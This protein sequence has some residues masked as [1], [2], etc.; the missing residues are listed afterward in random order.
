MA[1]EE[2]SA[3]IIDLK[4]LMS[5]QIGSETPPAE[6]FNGNPNKKPEDLLGVN[7][8]EEE[9]EAERI[10]A[11][12]E[13]AEAARIKAEEDEGKSEEELEAERIKAEE[14]EAARIKAEEEDKTEEEIEAERIKA[15][16]EAA[17]IKAE[18]GE[19]EVSE[20]TTSLKNLF[21]ED[22]SHIIQENDKGESVEIAL[23]DVEMTQELY[24]EIL[25]AK[26][27][28]IKE[29]AKKDTVSTEGISEF[30]RE[31]IEID[32]AGGEI[33]SLLEAKK[34]YSD[35]L[36]TLDLTK[37][38][39]Q[40]KAVFLR[41]KAGGQYSDEEIEILIKGYEDK[42]VLE[43]KATTADE[44]LKAAVQQQVEQAKQATLDKKAN[45]AKLTKEYEQDIEKNLD[46][47]ELED[48]IKRK[49]AKLSVKR[50]DKERFEI[51]NLY[52]QMKEDP[53]KAAQLALFILD[54]TEY[55]KQVSK[56]TKKATQLTSATK[57]SLVKKK[58]SSVAE[59]KNRSKK[60]DEG[61]IDLLALNQE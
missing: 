15:E 34:T 1:E 48:K 61:K 51:D 25:T 33:D 2:K 8:D 10:K 41:Y 36:D 14:E 54:T 45:I 20:Y 57:L 40:K 55:N 30:T 4:S 44:E 5:E 60:K 21:G 13:A 56:D 23:E 9:V 7:G 46:Q 29:E 35:V 47:F 22:I 6:P 17:R 11:E 18:G 43:D 38:E 58:T 50:D 53:K 24:E 26:M 3:T 39:D 37:K 42:G 12:E 32:R 19:G 28:E 59:A 16:E 31:L 52:F 27:A 49:I